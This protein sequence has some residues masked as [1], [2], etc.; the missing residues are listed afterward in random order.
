MEGLAR[1]CPCGCGEPPPSGRVSGLWRRGH[2]LRVRS[3]PRRR[4]KV[5]ATE[6]G[7]MLHHRW[8]AE[9]ALGHPLPAKAIVHHPDEDKTNPDA[10]LVICQD[11][12]YHSLLHA[13]MRVKAAGG[14][15]NSHKICGRCDA[16][17]PFE[18]FYPVA[19]SARC[20]MDRMSHCIEC[21]LVRRKAYYARVRLRA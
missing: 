8:R 21:E 10:R 7:Q 16:L 19:R 13:R 20:F 1:P 6:S 3:E 17:K 5:I 18:A 4:Y 2:N 12:R 14:D 11:T 9:Q 15:P